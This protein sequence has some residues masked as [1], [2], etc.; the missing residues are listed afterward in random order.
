MGGAL[1]IE[2]IIASA[3]LNST[4]NPTLDQLI[5]IQES[6]ILGRPDLNQES[7]E[8]LWDFLLSNYSDL[9]AFRDYWETLFA[10]L[11]MHEEFIPRFLAAIDSFVRV[12]DINRAELDVI[13]KKS[14]KAIRLARVDDFEMFLTHLVKDKKI[15]EAQLHDVCRVILILQRERQYGKGTDAPPLPEIQDPLEV[16]ASMFI[17]KSKFVIDGLYQIFFKAYAEKNGVE[18]TLKLIRRYHSNR[19]EAGNLE[20]TEKMLKLFVDHDEAIAGDFLAGRD[21]LDDHDVKSSDRFWS[22]IFL[23]FAPKYYPGGLSFIRMGNQREQG[24]YRYFMAYL[25]QIL[26]ELGYE[27]LVKKYYFEHHP[28][29]KIYALPED[30]R[31]TGAGLSYASIDYY[32]DPNLVKHP[33]KTDI[34][35]NWTADSWLAQD[36]SSHGYFVSTLAVGDTYGLASESRLHIIQFSGDEFSTRLAA[37]IHAAV[38]LKAKDPTLAVVGMSLGLEIP[39]EFTS[40]I[41]A[42]PIYQSIARDLTTLHDQGVIIAVAAGN[43][44]RE[45]LVNMIGLLPHL[46]TIGAVFSKGTEST[47]DDEISDYTTY[48]D[49]QNTIDFYAHADPVLTYNDRDSLIWASQGGTSSAQ[50]HFAAAILVLKGINPKLTADHCL[51]IARKTTTEVKVPKV[52]EEWAKGQGLQEI[53]LAINPMMAIV[54]AAHL[55]GSTYKDKR[56]EDLTQQ[57]IGMS[58][59]EFKQTTTFLEAAKPFQIK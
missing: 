28:Y 38:E 41:A 6:S 48:R 52:D 16:L 47:D 53:D 37:A 19:D 21:T 57:L 12:P 59:A 24:V 27:D 46:T 8:R 5:A 23:I 51:D 11:G 18:K 31:P 49:G 13:R 1:G 50:P 33:D 26:T 29:S 58:S 34:K 55:P 17:R 43:D 4:G 15:P 44:P 56:L 39:V 14:G 25:P 45:G 36:Q 2:E 22:I 42:S 32:P 7:K 35:T 20:S 40:L 30:L 10:F 3:A 54:V 9:A